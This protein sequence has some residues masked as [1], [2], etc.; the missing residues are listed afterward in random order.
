MQRN[1]LKENFDEQLILWSKAIILY[2]KKT[3][4]KS[5]AIQSLIKE[6]DVECE[7]FILYT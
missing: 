6:I 1:N 2:C 7:L 4:T 5:T 3:C